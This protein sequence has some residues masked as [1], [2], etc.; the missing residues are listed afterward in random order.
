M[1]WYNKGALILD[2]LM[3]LFLSLI[4]VGTFILVLIFQY[5]VAWVPYPFFI[6]I[7][8]SFWLISGSVLLRPEPARTVL[9][10]N[11]WQL[12]A[13]KC[14]RAMIQL[15]LI[16]FGLMTMAT[17]LLTGMWIQLWMQ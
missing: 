10:T 6:L 2:E 16:A 9:L 17:G 3:P 1:T 5:D 7:V 11:R 13:W 15:K 12:L 8:C 14:R 4:L